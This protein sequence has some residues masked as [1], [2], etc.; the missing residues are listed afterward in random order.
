MNEKITA[1]AVYLCEIVFGDRKTISS[2]AKI[3]FINRLSCNS[4]HEQSN[5]GTR[6][7]WLDS[8]FKNNAYAGASWSKVIPYSIKSGAKLLSILGGYKDF[9]A[10]F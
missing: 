3:F 8:N 7:N 1:L 4:V 2:E 6:R 10:F 9:R 5:E